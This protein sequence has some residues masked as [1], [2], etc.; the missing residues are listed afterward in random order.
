LAAVEEI[1]A[2]LLA[3]L[4]VKHPDIGQKEGAEIVRRYL[5]SVGGDAANNDS[6]EKLN[7]AGPPQQ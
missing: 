2:K 1:Q 7:R 6:K 3:E 4:K 5:A